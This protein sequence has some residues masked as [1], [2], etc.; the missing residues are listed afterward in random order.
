MVLFV[1]LFL[2]FNKFIYLFIFG[3]VGSSLLRATFSSWSEWG[4][5]FVAV[6]GLLTAVA[7]LV[8]EHGL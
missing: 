1:C 6:H 3:C 8:A 7:Y 2:F 5:L 4:L